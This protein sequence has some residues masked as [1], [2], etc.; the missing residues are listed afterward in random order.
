VVLRSLRDRRRGRFTR[1]GLQPSV[2]HS[3]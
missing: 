2:P 1:R 3:Q